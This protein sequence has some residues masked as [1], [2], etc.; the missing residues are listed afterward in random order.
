MDVPPRRRQ[1]GRGACGPTS[2]AAV[3][4]P[5]SWGSARRRRPS[6]STSPSWKTSRRRPRTTTR[7]CRSRLCSPLRPPASSWAGR[8]SPARLGAALDRL[9]A[10]GRQV[11]LV[12]G[13]PGIGKT[14]LVADFARTAHAGGARVLYGRC[15]EELGVAYQPFAEALGHYV[16]HCPLAELDAHVAAHGTHVSWVTSELLRRLPDAPQSSDH[17]VRGRP[18]PAVRGRDRPGHQ[19]VTARPRGAR[20]RRPPLGRA[21]HRRPPG[22]RAAGATAVA[23]RRRDVPPHRGRG[24]IIPWRPRWPTCGGSLGS[25][26]SRCPA[27]TRTAWRPSSSGPTAMRSTPAPTRWPGRCTP[28]RPATPSSW[29]SSSATCPRRRASTGRTGRWTYY[30]E[31]ESSGVPEGVRDVIARR[32]RRLSPSAQQHAHRSL[33]WSGSSSTSSSSSGWRAQWPRTPRSTPSTRRSP[34]MSSPRS[35]RAATSSP[36]PWCATRS[37]RR[38]PSPDGLASTTGS[39]TALASLP[40]DPTPRLPAL[41]HHFAE[42]ATDGAA[43]HAGRYGLAAARQAFDRSAWDDALSFARTAIGVLSSDDPVDLELR[44][45]LLLLEHETLLVLVDL[46]PTARVLSDAVETA[47]RPGVTRDRRPGAHAVVPLDRPGRSPRG[48]SGRGGAPRPRRLGAPPTCP[49]AGRPRHGRPLPGP[50]HFGIEHP[51]RARTRPG[52]G[53]LRSRV[54]RSRRPQARTA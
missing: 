25:T 15:D 17:G 28:A 26:G 21:A 43:T 29:A 22:P 12:G 40:G 30:E 47:R 27:S 1:P 31:A 44:F 50:G 20:P 49:P 54:R 53:G 11:V 7:R 3:S 6:A 51:G 23:S 48:R 35:D 38:S 2:A 33:R 4:S 19:G 37:T 9:A 46:P 5:R 14:A 41:A 45:E 18:L 8:P 16:A 42:A 34:P 39:A 36:M 10:D 24:R 13:E 32:L 52:V